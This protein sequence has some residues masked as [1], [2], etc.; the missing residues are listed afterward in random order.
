MASHSCELAIA[1]LPSQAAF[2]G[3]LLGMILVYYIRADNRLCSFLLPWGC[4]TL[5]QVWLGI[6]PRAVQTLSHARRFPELF[7]IVEF[8]HSVAE[9]LVLPY[10]CLVKGLCGLQL[11]LSHTHHTGG[12]CHAL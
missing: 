7:Q 5:P 2:D 10:G 3:L 1:E 6:V 12:S 11:L 9:R 4:V 8:I